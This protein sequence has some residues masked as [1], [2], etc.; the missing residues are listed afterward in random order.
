MNSDNK[1]DIAQRGGVSS[2]RMLET[3]LCGVRL[4]NPLI[5]AS[6]TFGFGMEYDRLYDVSCWGALTLKG[7]TLKP[8]AGNPPRRMVETASGMLNSV[9]LQNP[10]VDCFIRDDLPRIAEKG[11]PI[12]A[13]VSGFSE[14]EYVAVIRRLADTSVDLIELNISCPNVHCGGTHFATSPESVGEITKAVRAHCRQ[15]LI[16]KLSPN[17]T[18]ISAVAM[19]AEENGADGISLIN[20]LSGM[21]VDLDKRTPILANVTGGLSGPAIKPVALRMVWQASRTVKIPVVGMGGIMTGRDVAEFMTAGAKAV[22]IG[23]ANFIDPMSG[24]RILREF[25][26]YLEESGTTSLA[27]LIGSLK[28]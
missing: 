6:G 17:V 3:N 12:I 18:D 23:T 11:V 15:P 21:A 28:V 14:E 10:G 16:V 5:S 9:G 13:N 7:L 27:S 4:K 22:M 2:L 8:R 19:A 20:T 24:P 26:E 1:N 25:E